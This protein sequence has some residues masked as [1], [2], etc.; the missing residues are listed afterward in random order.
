M[1]RQAILASLAAAVLLLTAAPAE[2]WTTAYGHT[3]ARDR[4]L[5]YGCHSY[6]Y[7]YVVDA[8][9]HDWTLETF[10]VDRTGEKVSSNALSSDSEPERGYSRFGLCRWNTVPG[11]FA[12]R[13]KLVWYRNSTGH[14]AWFKPSHFWMRRPA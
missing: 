3:N 1:S 8:P 13:A 7:H 9:T 2:A 6:R 5:R 11:R 14:T 10:L 12:I 4:H